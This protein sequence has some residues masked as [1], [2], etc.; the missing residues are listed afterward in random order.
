LRRDGR[1]FCAE[2]YAGAVGGGGGAAGA[3]GQLKSLAAGLPKPIAGMLETVSSSGAAVA[4]GGASTELSDAWRSKVL[5]LCNAAF[6]R[7][8]F[9]AGSQ[10]DVPLDDFTHL[11][12]P[13]GL[14][15]AFFND[16]LKSLVD[17]SSTPWHWQAADHANLGLS[18]GTLTEF[19]RAADIRDA[20]FAGGS[21]IQVKFELVPVSLDPRIAK[22][23][24]DIAGQTMS[25]DHGPIESQGFTWPANGKTTVRVTITPTGGGHETTI[26]KNGPWSLLRLLDGRVTPSG[27]PDSFKLSF[28]AP[29][30][31]ATFTLNASSVRNP[32]TMSAIR[33]FRCP[34]HL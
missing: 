34:A 22:I 16:N 24:I 8:P 15:D 11:L 1:A 2:H 6:N 10:A 31:A 19:E 20:M 3:A 21:Q 14:M 25:Y 13:G 30:G 32:F 27:Q 18:P 28:S 5:P 7:Y 4:T 29:Q 12:G 33:S 17:T 23:S 9:I 26:E